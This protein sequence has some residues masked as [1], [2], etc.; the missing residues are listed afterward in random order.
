M[1]EGGKVDVGEGKGNTNKLRKMFEKK[2]IVKSTR[3]EKERL[4]KEMIKKD[5]GKEHAREERKEMKY[6]IISNKQIFFTGI[7]L[8]TLDIGF[9]QKRYST[10]RKALDIG[11]LSLKNIQS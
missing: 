7:S 3:I 1:N 8:I 5:D 11:N 6:N 2:E 4:W 9:S 10:L